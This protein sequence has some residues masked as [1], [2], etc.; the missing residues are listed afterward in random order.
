M[1]ARHE[2]RLSRIR[3]VVTGVGNTPDERRKEL[4]SSANGMGIYHQLLAEVEKGPII[5]PPTIDAR[6]ALGV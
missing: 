3:A 1:S 4:L 5:D 6:T 2:E